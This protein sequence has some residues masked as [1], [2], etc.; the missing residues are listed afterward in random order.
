MAAKY[1]S[2]MTLVHHNLVYMIMFRLVTS[3]DSMISK[4]FVDKLAV[5]KTDDQLNDLVE[6][7]MKN[8]FPSPIKKNW[9]IP[10]LEQMEKEVIHLTT[11][12]L[13]QRVRFDLNKLSLTIQKIDLLI[14][15]EYHSA[16]LNSVF[17]F[18]VTVKDDEDT[19][20]FMYRLLGGMI[21]TIATS[22]S[23]ALNFYP[24]LGEL[25][26]V[27][28]R[29]AKM[30]KWSPRLFEM[31]RTGAHPVLQNL[32]RPDE[33]TRWLRTVKNKKMGG[34]LRLFVHQFVSVPHDIFDA[35]LQQE[36]R[37]VFILY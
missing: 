24:M 5:A 29:L 8:Q 12:W 2:Y 33:V 36:E 22:R 34:V 1:A 21:Y 14:Q 13:D 23:M 7:L 35:E 30:S 17:N 9:N 37:L 27:S 25:G 18:A 10:N 32:N 31:I 3:K 4:A 16:S 19:I 26:T 20:D 15:S 28:E 6:D 11:D